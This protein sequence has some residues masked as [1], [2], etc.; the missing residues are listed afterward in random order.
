[1]RYPETHYHWSWPMR[2]DPETL[3]PLITDTN[4]FDRDSGTPRIAS[5]RF[6]GDDALTNAR[7]RVRIPAFL[8]SIEYVQ[9]PF[10]WTYP[11]RFG[12][13]RHFTAGPLADM[14][15]L[16]ELVPQ[17][18]GGT[19]LNYH[20]WM[21]PRNLLGL[22]AIPFQA[23]LIYR[24]TFARSFHNCDRL[25]TENQPPY[26]AR[27]SS[28]EFVSGGRKRLAAARQELLNEGADPVL[29]DRL[30]EVITLGDAV[31]LSHIRPYALADYWGEDR[32]AVLELCL[33]ATRHGLLDLRWDILCPA[34]RGVRDSL[35]TLGGVSR[36]VHC[37]VCQIDFNAHFE[38]S[39]ELTFSPNPAIRVVEEGVFCVGG[40]QDSPHVIAQQLIPAGETRTISPTL[41]Q[42]HYRVRALRKTGSQSLLVEPPPG[43]LA[44]LTLTATP[45]DWPPTEPHIST[46]PTL[47]LE[48][49]SGAEQLFILERFA[50]SDQ[51]AIAAEV[52][53]LQLFRDLFANEALRPGE[54]IAVGKLAVLF[55][56]LRGSTRLYREIGDAPAFGLVMDHF[57][58][59]R[60]IMNAEEGVVVKTLGDSIMAAFRDPVAAL[61]AA[62]RAQRVLGVSDADRP[63]LN[64]K[65]G[66]HFGPCIAVTLNERLD[67]FGSTV[68]IAARLE[69]LSEGD[70]V[71]ISAEVAA[72]PGV[73][74]WL[75][76]PDN[77]LT[78]KS[79][80]AVLKGF[81]QEYF[82][83]YSVRQN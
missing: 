26:I 46:T 53:M 29:V 77:G 41:E 54:Q 17:P 83:L 12:V 16:G 59:L 52:T 19:L 7:A 81:D 70:D 38:R 15:V 39:V 10:E 50:W 62:L 74:D 22:I 51:A 28:V 21:R 6:T 24:R 43:G 49:Q 34:C 64:L 42:G 25:A 1:M 80:E 63:P 33:V 68:N 75:A 37:D 56:D 4:R 69:S 23:G 58:V 13:T 61:R 9:E 31:A 36:T 14:R 30:V 32:T 5:V 44:E 45:H 48:N 72:D 35:P 3:W 66:L 67:Y 76:A 2:S 55:T 20:V 60:D 47:Y 82:S 18:E 71:I 8:L 11:Q 40:P 79:I 73:A 27:G 65:A 57:D 78:V